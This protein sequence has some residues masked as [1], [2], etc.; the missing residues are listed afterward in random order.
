MRPWETGSPVLG[1]LHPLGVK[2]WSTGAGLSM[3]PP[4][5]RNSS[6][7]QIEVTLETI[8]T[9][10][11]HW[12]QRWRNAQRRTYIN[13]PIL[14]SKSLQILAFCLLGKDLFKTM[15]IWLREWCICYFCPSNLFWDSLIT[16]FPH[17]QD[18]PWSWC[19][20]L[21]AWRRWAGFS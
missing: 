16:H 14:W 18:H 7:Y 2:P 3:S 6:W 13:N 10:L 1:P 8:K 21:P 4:V 11:Q 5:D 19:S 9:Y 12:K 17:G 15:Q 20:L